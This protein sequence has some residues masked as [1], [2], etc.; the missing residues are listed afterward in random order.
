MARAWRAHRA[1]LRAHFKENGGSKDLTKIKA[2][3]I[4]ILAKKTKNIYAICGVM[5]NSWKLQKR[6][7]RLVKTAKRKAESR[8]GSK[9]T[10]RYHFEHGHD[11]YSSSGQIDTWQLTHWEEKKRPDI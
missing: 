1:K 8:N 4:T 6:R 5:Q 7:L 10:I 2:S 3:P 11:L 9:S